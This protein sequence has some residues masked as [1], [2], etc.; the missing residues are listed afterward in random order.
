MEDRMKAADYHADPAP[1]PSL[2]SSI[3][4]ILVTRSPRHA[5][6]AHPRLN[7]NYRPEEDQ[8]FD[9]GSA[10]HELL[11]GGS[12]SIVVVEADDWRTKAAREQRD[13]IRAEGKLPLLARHFADVQKMVEIAKLAINSNED[14][15]GYGL[16]AGK[17]EQVLVWREDDIWCRARLD[18]LSNDRK[19]IYDYKS[20]GASA[21]PNAWI[22]TMLGMTG[23][24]QPA[25]Y[26]R[27]NTATG[28]PEDAR[29]VFL[30]QE[31]EPPFACSFVGMPPAFI[32]LGS[33]K[34]ARAVSLWRS[35]MTSGQWPSYPNRIHWAEPPE[36]ARA[37]WEEQEL[38]GFEYDPAVLFGETK[39]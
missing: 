1:V 5:W 8:K 27:G 11:L 33:R 13:A 29:F 39:S 31:N 32:D 15:K 26:L 4:A 25:F 30:V 18:W 36:W 12:D 37:Q 38:R 23:E 10:A 20:T 2:S 3:A 19:L 21:E 17:V 9:R 7:P 24:I 35:C 14:L 6:E 22:R 16:D 28:G 34:M